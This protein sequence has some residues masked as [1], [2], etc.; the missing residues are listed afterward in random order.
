MK[1]LIILFLFTTFALFFSC[2]KDNNLCKDDN[3]KKYFNIWKEL[4]ISRNQITEEY[5][6]EHIFPVSTKIDTWNDGKSFEIE[7]LIKI[8]W[9]EAQIRDQFIVWLDPSTSIFLP[10]QSYAKSTYLTKSQIS[11]IVDNLYSSSYIHDIA[12]VDKLK[13]N[14]INDAMQVLKTASGIEQLPDGLVFYKEPSLKD[15]PGNPNLRTSATINW[16]ENKC[17][18]CE[19]DLV[20]GETV[21]KQIACYYN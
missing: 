1:K 20:T 12:M 6:N 16:S 10:Y 14:S 11:S 9:T 2:E 8:D 21:I 5:F 19:I 3:C 15:C 13:Y 7:Y 17:L 4:L 18:N